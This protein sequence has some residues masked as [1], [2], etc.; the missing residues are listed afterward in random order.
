MAVDVSQVDP[1][2]A[3]LND[4][5]SGTPLVREK[6]DAWTLLRDIADAYASGD[7]S[8]S[9]LGS[10]V[11]EI[12]ETVCAQIASQGKSYSPDKL[13]DELLGLVKQRS[14]TAS[15]TRYM[16]MMDRLRSARERAREKRERLSVL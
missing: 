8:E 15:G 5:Y 9:E 2:L 1:I 13:A 10:Y 7:I 11:R 3:K 12:A 16:A 4:L 14:A 6:L